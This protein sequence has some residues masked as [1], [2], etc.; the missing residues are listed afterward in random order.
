MILLIPHISIAV[1]SLVITTL[2]AF[3]PS[4]LK[5]K[6]SRLF[7]SLTLITGTLL[8]IL[9]HQPILSSCMSGLVYL[10]FAMAGVI[11]GSRR[12]AKETVNNSSSHKNL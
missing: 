12:L 5:V 8:V 7:I 4:Q 2:T 10:G 11:I 9:T 6:L 3:A 1:I